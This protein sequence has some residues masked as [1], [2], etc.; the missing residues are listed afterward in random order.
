MKLFFYY[1][2][3]KGM[4]SQILC[5]TW[6]RT[7]FTFFLCGC[8][9]VTLVGAV[10]I[11]V[12][13]RL[14]ERAPSWEVTQ[15]ILTVVSYVISALILLLF[16]TFKEPVSRHF[17]IFIIN[18]LLNVSL[19]AHFVIF[20]WDLLPSAYSIVSHLAACEYAAWLALYRLSRGHCQWTRCQ[21]STQE[22]L[23]K[24]STITVCSEWMSWRIS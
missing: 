16:S 2:G 24:Q 1:R 8:V 10:V 3:L 15:I 9:I 20:I 17:L 14:N 13:D 5:F 23:W 4:H 12:C 18:Y 21:N 7:R 22:L 6:W 11:H 19:W